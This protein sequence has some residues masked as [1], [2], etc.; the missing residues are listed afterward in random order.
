MC[1]SDLC[2]GEMTEYLCLEVEDAIKF[3]WPDQVKYWHMGKV[4]K[5]NATPVSVSCG[6]LASRLPVTDWLLDTGSGFDLIGRKVAN[7]VHGHVFQTDNVLSMQTAN[8][9]T[10]SADAVSAEIPEL[11]IEITANI[12][13]STPSVLS[14]GK[15]CM[16]DGCSFVWI[17][18]STPYLELP[19]GERVSLQVSGYCPYLPG[20]LATYKG[21]ESSR[22]AVMPVQTGGSS[23]SGALTVGEITVGE[24]EAK[25]GPKP[26]KLGQINKK[27]EM[28][29]LRS[30]DPV[31]PEEIEEEEE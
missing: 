27:L 29:A 22:L 16:L 4:P 5:K 31:G 7:K 9:L 30:E 3:I 2:N 11:G 15:R 17:R 18:D 28:E 1:S 21:G 19:T 26:R 14:V 6:P 10:T 25:N 24:E 8:G 20:G 13:E 23:G 12:L